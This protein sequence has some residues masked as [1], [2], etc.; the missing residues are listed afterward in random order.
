MSKTTLTS[1]TDQSSTPTFLCS[2][3]LGYFNDITSYRAIAMIKDISF[4]LAIKKKMNIYS[5]TLPSLMLHIISPYTQFADQALF[6]HALYAS[7][8][9]SVLLAFP[10]P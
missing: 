2:D 7:L 6:H 1:V 8:R 9:G 3:V 4:I 5:F 10:L